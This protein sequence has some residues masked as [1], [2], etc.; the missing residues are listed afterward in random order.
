M[1]WADGHL[2]RHVRLMKIYLYFDSGKERKMLVEKAQ[3]IGPRRRD[4]SSLH[5][6][7]VKN[8]YYGEHTDE[9]NYQELTLHNL[10]GLPIEDQRTH[11]RLLRRVERVEG[12][13][14]EVEYPGLW[15]RAT[16]IERYLKIKDPSHMATSSSNHT[17]IGLPF[18]DEHGKVHPTRGFTFDEE[19]VPL[20]KR[21]FWSWVDVHSRA[22]LG[23]ERDTRE[24]IIYVGNSLAPPPSNQ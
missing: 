4:L 2:E 1:R 22:N 14:T 17:E 5:I 18:T 23:T 19:A 20:W 16:I 8:M 21:H 3:Q 11:L 13:Y 12:P 10:L 15:T 7:I 24:T 9:E 6:P